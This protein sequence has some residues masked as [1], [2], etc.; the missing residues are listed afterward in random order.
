MKF[1]AAAK[2]AKQSLSEKIDDSFLFATDFIFSA[3]RY[4][5]KIRGMKDPL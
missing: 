3:K 2:S 5:H 4:A 1:I